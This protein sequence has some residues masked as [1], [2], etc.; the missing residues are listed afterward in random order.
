MTTLYR[1]V[2]NSTFNPVNGGTART[3][4]AVA[5]DADLGTAGNR[6]ALA[7][8][9]D[10]S[11]TGPR[12]PW[13]Q[14][15]TGPAALAA[16][17]A[18]PLEADGRRYLRRTHIT[19]GITF[20]A[21]THTDIVFEDCTI[22]HA[23]SY[24]VSA[25]YDGTNLPAGQLPEFRFCEITGG[26]SATIAG[27]STRFLRCDIHHGEDLVKARETG[28]EFYACYL[29]DPLHGAESHCDVF[30]IVSAAVGL[31]IHWNNAIALN[32]PD[33]PSAPGGWSNGVLQTG[34]VTRAI[35][36]VYW[37]DNWFDGGGY[38]IRTGETTDLNGNTRLYDFRR[39]RFGRAYRWGPVLGPTTGD[40]YFD[41]T[42]VWADTGLP[43]LG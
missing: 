30:Q 29:H 19:S 24:T 23:G 2:G 37:H 43:V 40:V 8:A 14:A 6:P 36:P 38:T 16:V 35:G 4:D 12:Q 31:L 26:T 11:T 7:T 18:A 5:F 10:V 1:Y 20:N 22:N 34:S 39:N 41:D 28:G 9:P 25:F 3:L 21:A 32:A 17:L 27:C 13:T 15:M 42:N 33:S